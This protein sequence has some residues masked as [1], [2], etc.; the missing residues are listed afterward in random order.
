MKIQGDICEK[1]QATVICCANEAALCAKCYIEVHAANKLTTKGYFFNV[2]PI[3]FFNGFHILSHWGS[4]P[5]RWRCSR[6]L[7]QIVFM[8]CC[9]W[10]LDW[11]LV[12]IIY[13]FGCISFIGYLFIFPLLGWDQC[14]F[15]LVRWPQ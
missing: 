13:I 10:Q 9:S 12:V 4:L 1:A 3:S 11:K 2:S 15:G 7:G 5:N 14:V 6:N 8:V